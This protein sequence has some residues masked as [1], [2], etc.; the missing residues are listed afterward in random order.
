MKKP[1]HTFICD[2][3]LSYHLAEVILFIIIEDSCALADNLLVTGVWT[4]F[5]IL[6]AASLVLTANALQ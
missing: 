5:Q 3:S 2:I 4:N 1:L 6:C